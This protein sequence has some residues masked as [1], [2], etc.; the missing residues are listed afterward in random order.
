MLGWAKPAQT[1]S[2]EG[3]PFPSV[4]SYGNIAAQRVFDFRTWPVSHQF[5]ALYGRD[6]LSIWGGAPSRMPSARG[7]GW[8]TQGFAP[9]THSRDLANA[10]S[11]PAPFDFVENR[12]GEVKFREGLL[13]RTSYAHFTS[14]APSAHFTGYAYFTGY[15]HFTCSQYFRI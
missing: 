10:T 6:H 9:I 14:Y 5:L 15:A 3:V 4:D 12:D 1:I 13:G 2:S 8:A 7:P 11:L